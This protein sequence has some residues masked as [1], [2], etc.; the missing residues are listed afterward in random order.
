MKKVFLVCLGILPFAMSCQK[1]L[2]PN[3][4]TEAKSLVV[5]EKAFMEMAEMSTEAYHGGTFVYG[6][7]QPTYIYANGKSTNGFEA[8]ANCN[9]TITIDTLAPTSQITIDWGTSNCT[10]NDF[11][12]RRGKLIVTFNGGYLDSGTVITYTPQ[13][14]YV[15]DNKIEGTMKITN[16]GHN[17]SGQPFYDVD[18]DGT[19]TLKTGE[20]VNYQSQR[21]RTFTAGYNTVLNYLD[22]EYDI[23]GTAHAQIVGGE[24]FDAETLSPVHFK[25]SCPYLTKGKI[26]ITPESTNNAPVELD[27]GNGDCDANFTATYNGHTYTINVI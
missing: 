23:T 8:K 6:I 22:D 7:D 19:V 27:F 12:T 21:V 1:A 26:K 4:T 24:K 11:K 16:K 10:C 5:A 9:V 25:T 17:A 20:Q 3:A 15:N 14:Y 13:D 2:S 18:I